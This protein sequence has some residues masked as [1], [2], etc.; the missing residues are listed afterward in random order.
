VG[1]DA[2]VSPAGAASCWSVLC[3]V[4]GGPVVDD[5]AVVADP[6]DV[7][8]LAPDEQVGKRAARAAHAGL[9]Q[10]AGTAD[11]DQ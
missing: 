2:A 6:V 11:G 5:A 1:V 3:G 4:E 7:N 8:D 9:R 10:A